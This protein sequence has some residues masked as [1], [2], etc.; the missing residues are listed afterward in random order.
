M[1]NKRSVIYVGMEANFGDVT[2]VRKYVCANFQH[3]L[4]KS[5]WRSDHI[6]CGVS[7][8][9]VVLVGCLNEILWE[10]D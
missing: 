3:A 6:G 2:Y 10:G 1:Q 9:L 5:C 7:Y 4:Q 8:T